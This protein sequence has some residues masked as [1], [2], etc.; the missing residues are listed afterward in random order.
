VLG[1]PTPTGIY[2]FN[3][4]VSY[5]GIEL[6]VLFQG[7]T[8]NKIFDGAGSFMSANGRYEDNSTVDQLRRWQNPGDITDV[9]QARLYGNNGAQSSSRFLYD[10]SYLRLKTLIVAYNVPS[11]IVSKLTLTSA[12]IYV[13]GQ[14]LLTFT[15][16][17]GWD[18]EV[19]TDFNAS[20]VNLG[21]DFY[22]APQPKN[23][24]VGLKVGF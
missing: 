18:P 16:Y 7:V 14:N 12:R 24:T 15:N 8:G 2:G 10:G 9:P 19:N 11:A 1:N 4:N 20:N 22:A 13:S 3:A 5:K 6:S 17:K 21:N 23:F